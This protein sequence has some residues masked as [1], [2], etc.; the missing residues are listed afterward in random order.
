[1]QNDQ[2]RRAKGKGPNLNQSPATNRQPPTASS[3]VLRLLGLTAFLIGAVLLLKALLP[4]PKPPS[5]DPQAL[6]WLSQSDAAMNKLTSVQLLRTTRGDAGEGGVLTETMTFEAPDLFFSQISS[7]NPTL[8]SNRS[9][10]IAHGS[11]Q[12][13]RDAGKSLWQAVN[14]VEPFRFSDFNLSEQALF[15]KLA[16]VEELHGRR[17]QRVTYTVYEGQRSFAFTRW[18]DVETKLILQEY[19]DA[20]GHHMLSVYH[21]YDAPVVISIPAPSE[22]GPTPTAVGQ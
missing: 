20:P 21:D 4:P 7:Y 14:R 18:V 16:G 3:V 19:M 17:A 10:S 1:M 13:Y 11:M 12:Y 6:A 2:G 22:I 9:E 5:G 8:G 15:A